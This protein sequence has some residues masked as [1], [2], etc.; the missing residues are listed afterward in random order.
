MAAVVGIPDPIR[1][2]AIK[3]WIVLKSEIIAS[4]DL[5]TEIQDSSFAGAWLLTNIRATLRLLRRYP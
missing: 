4:D 3:A 5:K 2:E 1:T